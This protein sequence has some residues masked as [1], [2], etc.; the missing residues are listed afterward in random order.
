[1]RSLTHRFFMLVGAAVLFLSG[2]GEE[3]PGI[4]KAEIKVGTWAPLTGPAPNLGVSAKGLEAYFQ[5]VNDEGGVNG[6]K[7]TLITKDDGYD[8]ARTPEVVKELVEQDQ[9]FAIVGGQGTANC[10]AV[11]DYL[12]QHM[13][14]WVNPGSGARVWTMPVQAYVFSIYPY[15]VTEGQVLGRYAV[16]EMGADR[17]GLFYQDDAFGREG[18]EGVRTGL[19]GVGKEPIIELPYEVGET[20]FSSQAQKLKDEVLDTVIMVAIPSHAARLLEEIQKMND[21][22]KFRSQ[23]FRPK[24][25]GNN[26]L[27]DPVMLKV[28]EGQ[29]WNG[30]VV[31]SI[32]PD[33][34]SDEP[35]VVRAREIAEKYV[36]DIPFG[37]Y[38]LIGLMRAELF[39]EGARRAGPHINR[40]RLLLAFEGMENW[41]DNILGQPITFSKE[42]HEGFN[43]VRLM[44][45]EDGKYVSVSDWTKPY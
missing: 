28:A 11:K 35:G 30:A 12:E 2:C 20:D 6:R 23:E 4:S 8:P 44:K 36:P 33:P 9:V 10:M 39:V 24:F 34:N 42:S 1:M 15:Y 18:Q 17:I 38:L 22:V 40:I 7:L 3:V 19:R 27:S 5:Y 29:L 31:T 45:A 13:I 43:S 14:P 41:S 25:L 37:S 32:V 21:Q 26:L 16:E